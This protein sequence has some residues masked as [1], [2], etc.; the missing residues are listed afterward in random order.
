[1]ASFCPLDLEK[2][3]K[4]QPPLQQGHFPHALGFSQGSRE[5]RESFLVKALTLPVGG[6]NF[7]TKEENQPHN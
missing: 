7:N 4:P 6:E 2:G 1:M 5:D 3:L